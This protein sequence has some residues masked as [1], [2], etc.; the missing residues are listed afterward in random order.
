MTAPSA[1]TLQSL[2]PETRARRVAEVMW[3]AE[4]ASK[5]MGLRLDAVGPGRAEMSMTVEAHHANA[6]GICH[7]GIIFTLADSAFGFACN[8]HGNRTVAAQNAITFVAP[9][10]PGD[11]LTAVAVETVRQGRSGVCDVTVTNQN[12]AVIA[13]MRGH[14]REIGGTHIP[15]ETSDG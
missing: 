1:P 10:R 15:E 8:T 3:A 9:S 5:W 14:S 2:D 11:R 13:L 12:G 6:Q 4:Q 7:G